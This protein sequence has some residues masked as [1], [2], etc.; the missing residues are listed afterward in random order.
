MKRIFYHFILL[1]IITLCNI[2]THAQSWKAPTEIANSNYIVPYINDGYFTSTNEGWMAANRGNILHTTDGGATWRNQTTGTTRDLFGIY[3]INNTQGWAVGFS[4][5]IITT[6]DGGTTW[7]AQASG[8]TRDLYGV[9]FTS[10]TQGWAVGGYGTILT[11]S[12]GGATWTAQTSGILNGLRKVV[13]VSATKGWVI[14]NNGKILTTSDGGSTWTA[15]TSGITQQLNGISF[16]SATN[17][18]VVGNEG[19]ILTTTNGGSTWT[20]QTSGTGSTVSLYGVHLSSST[21]GWATGDYNTI[22]KTTNGGVT[23]T[24]QLTEYNFH[25]FVKAFFISPTKG[26]AFSSNGRVLTTNNGNT[27]SQLAS[28]STSYF[29]EIFFINDSIGW[30]V[31]SQGTIYKSTDGGINWTEKNSGT[32]KSLFSVHFVN[33]TRGWAVGEDGIIITTNDGGDTWTPQTSGTTNRLQSVYFTDALKGWAVGFSGNIFRTTNGGDSWTSQSVGGNVITI[34]KIGFV[35]ALNGWATANSGNTIITNDG[36]NT[37]T[38]RNVGLDVHLSGGHFVSATHGWAGGNYLSNGVVFRTTDGGNTWSSGYTGYTQGVSKIHFVNNNVGWALCGQSLLLNT[39]DGGSSWNSTY[40]N[41]FSS[42]NIFFRSATKGWATGQDGFVNLYTNDT[43]VASEIDIK[44]NNVSI[45]S[46]DTTPSTSDDTDFGSQA[47]T[48]GT[49]DKTFTI[50]NT[51]SAVLNLTGT[52]KVSINGTNASDFTVVS[53]P[54]SPVTANSGTTTFQIRFDPSA[55]GL[56]TATVSIAND[57]ADENPYTF[58]IQGTG[59]TTTATTTTLTTNNNPASVGGSIEFTATVSPNTATGTVIFRDNGNNF[60]T[61]TL[62]NGVAKFR[63]DLMS[64]GTHSMTA[65]YL[66]DASSLASTSSPVSQVVNQLT[67]PNLGFIRQI[68]VNDISSVSNPLS[69]ATDASGNV[70]VTGYF[71]NS[72]IL[73]GTTLTS[74]GADDIFLAKYD[75]AGNL[76]WARRA[77]GTSSDRATAIAVSDSDVYITGTFYGTASFNTPASVGTYE[78]TSAGGSDIFVAKYTDAGEIQWARRAGGANQDS[79]NGITTLGTD[80]Y[81]SGTFESTANFNTPSNTGSNSITSDGEKDIFIAKFSSSGNYQWAKRAGGPN[82]ELSNKMVATASHIYLTGS[83]SGTVN[84]NTPS[85]TSSNVLTSIGGSDIFLAKY[86]PSGTVEWIKRGG[87]LGDDTGYGITASETDIYLT[88]YFSATANFN[89]PSATG[90]NELTSAGEYDLFVAKYNFSGDVQWLKRAGGTGTDAGVGIGV[91]GSNVYLT[92]VFSVNANFNTPSATGINEITGQGFT[93]HFLAK[94]TSSGDYISSKV[95]GG[96]NSAFTNTLA[97][98]GDKVYVAGTFSGAIN[99]NTPLSA[100]SNQLVSIATTEGFLAKYDF[101]S[102]TTTLTSNNNPSSLGANVKLSATVLPAFTPTGTVT[103]KDGATILGTVPLTNNIAT[104]STD[105]LTVG[106]HTFTAE[107]NGD[108]FHESSMSNTVS[109]VVNALTEPQLSFIRQSASNG[110]QFNRTAIDASGNIYVAG[111]FSGS[112]TIGGIT[113]QGAGSYDIFVAKFNSSGTLQWAKRAGGTGDDIAFGLAVSGNDIYI[114]GSF[115][116]TANFNTPSSS[117]SNELV[118][119]GSDGFIAKYNASGDVQWIKRTGG[120]GRGITLSGTDIYVTGDFAGTA[121]FNNPSASGSNELVSAGLSDIYLAKYN[122]SGDIQWARRGGGTGTE[123]NYGAIVASGSDIYIAAAF[124]STANFNTPAN[125]STNV[126]TSAGSFDIFIA[127]FNSSGDCQWVRRGGG[128]NQ[129][130]AYG[131]AIIGNDVYVG[132]VFLSTANFNTP[133]ASGSFE[134]TDVLNGDAFLVKYNTNGVIQWAKRAGGLYTDGATDIKAS[135]TN[136]FMVGAFGDTANFNTPSASGSNEITSGGQIDGFLAVYDASGN[137]NR[138]KRMGGITLDKASS[139]AVSDNNVVVV[140]NFSINMNFSNPSSIG[141]NQLVALNSS[142][143]FLA[144]YTLNSISSTTTLTS[145]NNPSNVGNNV[146]FTATLTPGIATGTVTFKEGA[147]VLGTATL[148]GGTA[149]LTINTLTAGTHAITAEYSGDG[150]YESSVSAT[151]SQVV[152]CTAPTG[153]ANATICSGTTASLSASC[154]TGTVA[155][156]NST[157]STRLSTVSPFVTPTLSENTVYNV[158]CEDT[159]CNSAFIGVSVTVNAAPN[160]TIAYPAPAICKNGSTTDIVRTGTSGGTFSSSPSGLS[161]NSST[162]R[163]TPGTSTAGTYT[164][165]LTIAASGSCPVY[166]ATTALTITAVPSATIGYSSNAFCTT[167]GVQNV[168]RTGT[169]GGTYSA[170]PTGLSID[171]NTGQITPSTSSSGNYVVYYSIPATGGCA[172]YQTSTNVSIGTPANATIAYTGSPF[173]TTS[174]VKTV[175]RTGTTG[176]LFSSSPAGLSINSSTGQITPGS[177]SAGTY[178]ISY[179]LAASGGCPAFTTTTSIIVSAAPNA[180]ISYSANSFCTTESAKSVSRTGTSGGTYSVQPSGLTIDASTGQITPATSTVNDYTVYYTIPAANGCA[181]FQTSYNVSIRQAPNAAISYTGSP[182]CSTS[183][184]VNVNLTGT[185]GGAFTSTP[186]GLTINAGSGQISPGTSSAGNYTV[187]YTIA[188]NGGCAA[189]TTTANVAI[190]TVPSATIAYS[191]SPFCGVTSPI[192]VSRIG[193]AGGTFASSPVGLSINSS[194]GQIT[195]GSSAVGTYTVTYSVAGA[196]PLYTATT[197]ISLNALP[198]VPTNVATSTNSIC[199]SGSVSLSATCSSGTLTWYNQATGGTALGTGFPLSQTP[200]ITTT[201]YAACNNGACESSRVATAAVVVER[202]NI[203]YDS[204]FSES[205]GNFPG[206]L[207]QNNLFGYKIRI[208]KPIRVNAVS[209]ILSQNTNGGTRIRFA[210]YSDVNNVPTNLLASSAGNSIDTTPALNAGLNSF[211]LDNPVTLNCGDY[212]IAYLIKGGGSNGEFFLQNTQLPN[213]TFYLSLNFAN[214]F[215]A[216]INAQDVGSNGNNIHNIYLSGVPDCGPETPANISVSTT[217]VC[218]G[219]SITL[220]ATCSSGVVQWY[221]SQTGNTIVGTGTGLSVIVNSNTTYYASCKAGEL[222]GCRLPT[223]LVSVTSAPSLTAGAVTSPTVCGGTDGKIAFTTTLGN[224]SYS[225]T[226]TGSG[227][228]RTINALNGAFEL[229]GL[230]AGTYSDFAI[231]AS[232]CTSRDATSKSIADPSAPSAPIINAP[233]QKIVCSPNALTLTASGCAGTI[234]WSNGS[235]GTSLTLSSIGTYAIS[236]TCAVNN[237]TSNTS[238]LVSGL[239]ILALPGTPAITAPNQKVVCAPNTLTLTASGCAGTINW[240]TGASGTSLT[241]SSVG[242]YSITA[243]CTVGSCISPA[244]AAVTGLQIVAPPTV[245]ISGSINLSC[246]VT[247][248]TRTAIGSGVSPTYQWSNGLGTDAT[249]TITSP[250]TYTV[251]VSGTNNCTATATTS[252]IVESS[253]PAVPTIT[254]PN[255]KVVCAPNTLILTASGCGGTVN[256]STGASGTSLTLSSVGTYSITA[257]CTVGSCISP[258]SSAVT[259]LEIVTQPVAPTITSPNQK[260]VCAPNTLILTASGCAGTVSWSTGASGTSL[261][262]SSVGTYSITATCTVGSCISPASTAV[263]GLEIVTQPIA[264]TI[265]SP[266]QKVVCAPN[267]LTLTASGCGGTVN[268]STGA[269]GTSLTLSSVGTYS[270]TATCTV[271]S[272]ISPASSAVTGLEIVT[273][274]TAPTITAPNQKVVCSPNTL[275]LTAS[276][277]G[278]TV[279]WST[280]ASGTSLT[281]SSVG[282]YSITATCTVGSC[283]SPASSAVMGLEIVTQPIAPTITAPNQKVVCA[284]NTLTLTASGCAGTVNWSTGASGTSLILSSVGTY[285]ITATCTVG[286]CISPASTAVTGLEIVTQPI[287]PTITVPNQKVVCAPNTLTLTASGCAGTVNWSTGASGTSLTLSSAGTYSITATCTVG[288]CISP[289]ST[290]VTG[291]QI[292]TQPV[293]PTITAPNQKVVC[294]PNTLTLTASGCAGTVNWSTGTSGTSLTLSSVGTYSITATCTVGSCISPASTAVTGLQIVTQPVAPT[295]TAPNQKVVCAPNTLTLTASGCAGTVNWSTGTSGTSLTLSSVGTYSITATCT[296]GS[297]ISPASSAVTGL[298]IVTQPVAPTITAPNQKVV[299]APNTLTL[300]ASGCGGTVNWSTGTSGTSLTLSSVGTYS[301]TATCTVGSCIS[302]ASSAVTGLEIVTQPIAPTITAPNQKVVCAP[303]TL[304]L[305]ASGCAGTVNWSTG[306][307]GTSLTLSSVGTYSITATCNIGNC[308]GMA[309]NVVTG[310]QIIA[311]PVAQASNTGPYGVG[312]TIE[313]S[314]SGGTLYSW[315]GPA[316]FSS[317]SQNPTLS[318]ALVSNSGIYTVT[319]STGVCTATATTSVIVNGTDP[320]VQ[321]VDLQYVKAGNPYEPLFSLKD[322]MVIQ[323]VPEQVSILANPV[324][325]NIQVGSVDMTITGPEINWTILQN[326]QPYAVFDNLGVNVYGRNL[327]PGTYTI[328]VTGYQDDNRVGGVVYGPVVTTFTVVGTM[329]VINA[330]AIPDNRLCAGSI[331]NVTFATTGSFDSGNRFNIQLSDST[332]GFTNPVLI[333]TT[334]TA[335]TIACQLPQNLSAT[336]RYL[337]RVVSSDQV[338]ASNPTMQYLTIIPAT[339]SLTANISSGT[340]TEQASLQINASNKII[341]P[342]N[343][344]YNAGKSILLNPGFESGAGSIFKAQIQGCSN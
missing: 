49:I 104:L 185:G 201:Y 52:P 268:W 304:I 241:L 119:T 178:T 314:A 123:M 264:P 338:V 247:S 30:A 295:I 67:A 39:T 288:S 337:I 36:G 132:G 198:G 243:T 172:S 149:T 16:T 17:G 203:G 24:E 282:T 173:C 137:V 251:T 259:G 116:G 142:E 284:P 223:S 272:C 297:C 26:W 273:Q 294:A 332:G 222:E 168:T 113:L 202:A 344:T 240:S 2:N 214:A 227:S 107:Y 127:K 262:L 38:I 329:A 336:G 33:E 170:T 126:V 181:E 102:T 174:S 303:N 118:N 80:V 199:G 106:T 236:A 159:G 165:T 254:A 306:A 25:Q 278:G 115:T 291:L 253:V 122:T 321:I 343:V 322:G 267:A 22:L 305:T 269:S 100:G 55:G 258:A 150:V 239:E 250:G 331:V 208:T 200:E 27:W 108:N 68:S 308:T 51:G 313:L 71:N 32:T 234:R 206:F 232:G 144:K 120:P 161:L 152:N 83:F 14:G 246:N 166:T 88:G 99:F 15:Q 164:V 114:T 323:Q 37:W 327:I 9:Y 224:G 179:S 320:C 136:I 341:S 302:P 5:T 101:I 97:I 192:E 245:S 279:N 59:T 194:T 213:A 74:S 140:G 35:D 191:G 158:R 244:S 233:A 169:S 228:P 19:K 4:G 186:T 167:Q 339:K 90:S 76:L 23:W 177:S 248:V 40:L 187:T 195:P 124:E 261:T 141:T 117:G 79:G 56:R 156:Y 135:D 44:G 265:T 105:L 10:S 153:T 95:A 238:S 138:L 64:T 318:N 325:Q 94:Y 270:I 276:G 260:V 92:G 334:A 62:S 176:G 301:I 285:S 207:V 54:V 235:S 274:P 48:S 1:F 46:G 289:A 298:E 309:S 275:T 34:Y 112:T 184:P 65:D 69:T 315:S 157:S 221:N 217:T 211:L 209:A 271:G 307:S 73:R 63:T 257:T 237:C 300:T 125:N 93:S 230:S 231:T 287:A 252:V 31:G 216:T 103:F 129:D 197:S 175:S 280:G 42:A 154:A 96:P 86:N 340:S 316:S 89:T 81:V 190:S 290:A 6:N 139:V 110:T 134:I 47:V 45:T 160:T 41:V 82:S 148:S 311:P 312:Q 342:A 189:F 20:S 263:T 204:P 87:G 229:T 70:Y 188:A 205:G 162:G 75:A 196:C 3:F 12:D 277:C 193:T 155:W 212:W 147:T 60:G 91:S 220:S 242:T 293:V 66:G 310:L 29:W 98:A 131:V 324:C 109:Q 256:W 330:P 13:F 281:L 28:G 53:L 146:Q 50:Y 226:F 296:V 219:A 163:I 317:S 121:N 72:I 335:G 215:P 183:A 180:S 145:N 21:E 319:V 84:F 171:T 255:Q 58:A 77:G 326:V 151:L 143:G 128:T 57:D 43:A 78:V 85:S 292:V 61:A 18:C 299:C 130:F 7:T 218:S 249:V 266:N 210:I 333:G 225:I 111:Q 8:S 182:F 11:T 133:S 286:S 328:T 283:I